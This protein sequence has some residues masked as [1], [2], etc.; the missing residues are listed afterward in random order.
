MTS[1]HPLSKV[2]AILSKENYMKS[3]NEWWD[4]VSNQEQTSH[5]Q[6]E[7]KIEVEI[8]VEKE[9]PKEEDL[10]DEEK[11]LVK[12]LKAATVSQLITF[13]IHQGINKPDGDLDKL[14]TKLNRYIDTLKSLVEDL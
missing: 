14:K 8:E 7:P 11:S 13:T 1:Y 3:L 10:G 12:G 6:E 4:I 2:K 5:S 9:E